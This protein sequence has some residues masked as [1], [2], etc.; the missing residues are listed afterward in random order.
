MGEFEKGEYFADVVG[1]LGQ[2]SELIHTDMEELKKEKISLCS[3]GS[4]NSSSIS[5]S[6]MDEGKWDRC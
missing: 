6:K 3:W 1:P 2:P 4:R 5:T